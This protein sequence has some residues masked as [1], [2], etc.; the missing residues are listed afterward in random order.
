MGELH[1]TDGALLPAYQWRAI[2]KASTATAIAEDGISA[3]KNKLGN[4][5]VWWIPTLVGLGS[6]INN[7]Y[8]ELNRFLAEAL[9]YRDTPI[10]FM[11]DMPQK[12]LLMKTLRFKKE[13][14]TIVVNKSGSRSEV[15]LIQKGPSAQAMVLFANKGGKAGGD[16]INIDNEETLVLKWL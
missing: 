11:F 6:R 5:T 1:L 12:G 13:A 9:D 7:D 2:L 15:Q 16:H 8:S 14:V 10:P 4:G 3:I